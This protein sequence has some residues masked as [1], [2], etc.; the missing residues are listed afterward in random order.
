[1]FIYKSSEIKEIDRKTA[2]KG[3]SL[4]A[5]MENAG[6][7]LFRSIQPILKK[8]DKILIAAG[9][10]NNGGDG[11][12]LARYLKNNGYETDL[13][14]P[15]GPPKTETAK[16]HFVYFQACHYEDSEFTKAKKYDWIIDGLLGV[17][18]KLPLRDNAAEF[19]VWLN[20]QQASVISIDVPTG[21]SSDDG[22]V[23]EHAVRADYTFSLHG[24]KPSAFLFPSSEYYGKIN[25]VDIGIPHEGR[26]RVWTEEDVKRTFPK[27]AGNTHK[28]TFGTGLL[29]AGSDEMPGSAALAAIGAMRFGAGKLTIA[30]TRH[31]SAIIGPHV[32]EATFL[33]DLQNTDM[34]H[35]S[36]VAIGPGLPPDEQLEERI[37]DILAKSIPVILDAGA[38]SKRDYRK[39]KSPVIIT[40]HPGEFSRLTGKTTGEIQSNR[41]QLASQYAVENDVIVILKGKYTV[42]AFPD[43]TGLV[44]VTGN[45]ALSKGGTGD[46]LT[47]MLLAAAGTH[48]N[49]E[50]A[51]ANAVFFHGKC[52]DKWIITNGESTMVAHDFA[53]LLPEVCGSY[54]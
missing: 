44:N 25:V 29:V 11:I 40:P 37:T 46:T 3:M 7:G 24:F 18:S 15:M 52:G 10:G 13:I 28:G 36:A 6:S 27:R 2:E 20:N 30:T 1:M 35:F 43:G 17:G 4:F 14:F 23:D 50:E 47:G 42:I 9:P 26:F 39:R 21:V 22:A 54:Q 31:A 12:V 48:K 53:V 5:L 32:P 45:R 38:L 16:E 34:S 51:V 33:F 8:S 41:L 19:I 49:I